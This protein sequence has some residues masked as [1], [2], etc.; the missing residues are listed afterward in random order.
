[1]TEFQITLTLVVFAVVILA[2]AFD[3][4]DMAL[5]ALLGTTV[6]VA[7]GILVKADA[8]AALETA[9]GPLALLFGGMVVARMLAMTGLFDRIGAMF[10][11]ATRGSGKRYL[12]LL[13]ALVAG[14]RRAASWK[15]F[16]RN[17]PC[18]FRPRATRW[19]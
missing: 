5:A 10:L 14:G 13:V 4:I 12:I 3:A 8:Y 9:S 16:A 11:R 6:L 18:S 15:R 17:K 1:M 7:A 2:I 19:S